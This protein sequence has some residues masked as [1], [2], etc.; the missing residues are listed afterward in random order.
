MSRTVT[1]QTAQPVPQQGNQFQQFQVPHDKVAMR[2]YDKWVKRGRA[3]GN[4]EK[5]WFEAEQELKAEFSKGQGTQ[6][7]PQAQQRR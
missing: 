4:P 5:D 7:Q 1:P 3:P 6:N 2:A